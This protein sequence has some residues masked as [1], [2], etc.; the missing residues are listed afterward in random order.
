MAT[1][2]VPFVKLMIPTEAGSPFGALAPLRKSK[3]H[4]IHN[5]PGLLGVGEVCTA[6]H[7]HACYTPAVSFTLSR[8][9]ERAAYHI[10]LALKKGRQ[11]SLF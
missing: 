3:M 10:Q 7:L 9:D 2:T 5:P 8:C 4:V 11:T 6:V 1:T